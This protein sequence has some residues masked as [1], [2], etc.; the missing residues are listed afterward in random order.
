M[1]ANSCWGFLTLA[2]AFGLARLSM[3]GTVGHEEWGTRLLYAAVFFGGLSVI[4]F[5]WP[6]FKRRVPI[7]PDM[8][9]SDA[10]DY[11]VND[12]SVNLKKSKP[13]EINGQLIPCKGAEHGD[14]EAHI[15]TALN[16]GNIKAW[17]QKELMSNCINFESALRPIEQKYWQSACLAP[18]MCYSQT[19]RYAQTAALPYKNAELY[20]NLMLNKKE[21]RTLFPPSLA[22]WRRFFRKRLTYWNN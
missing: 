19:D 6:L 18:L 22:F 16:N 3:I 20:T 4:C 17:G 8:P 11:L 14:A 21:V 15:Q 1:W 9:I 5:F 12:S 7:Q 2:V 10:I 13:L